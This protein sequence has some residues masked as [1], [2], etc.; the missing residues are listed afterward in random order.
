MASNP[1][2]KDDASVA[3]RMHQKG[4]SSGAWNNADQLDRKMKKLLTAKSSRLF[5]DIWTSSLGA[6]TWVSPDPVESISI[7]G[8]I[9]EEFT[10]TEEGSPKYK[11]ESLTSTSK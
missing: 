7:I 4:L 2:I 1:H 6:I 11:V 5:I 10:V 9:D 8:A 3:V